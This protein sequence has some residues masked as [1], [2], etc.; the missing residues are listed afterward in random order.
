MEGEI[1]SEDLQEDLE[2][3]EEAL[4]EVYQAEGSLLFGWTNQKTG[5]G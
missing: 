1:E 5:G 2:E 3:V 4:M